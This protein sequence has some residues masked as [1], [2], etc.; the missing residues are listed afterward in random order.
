V[1][2]GRY[3]YLQY[4]TVVFRVQE[5]DLC[6]FIMAFV[7]VFVMSKYNGDNVLKSMGV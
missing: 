2:F 3:N 4:A 7:N 1:L 5:R 6:C